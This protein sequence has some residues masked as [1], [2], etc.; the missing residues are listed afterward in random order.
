MKQNEEVFKKHFKRGMKTSDYEM[1]KREYPTLLKCILGA[2]NEVAHRSIVE[3][4]FATIPEESHKR[5]KQLCD[6]VDQQK[7]SLVETLKEH[8]EEMQKFQDEQCVLIGHPENVLGLAVKGVLETR[9]ISLGFPPKYHITGTT[10]EVVL[11]KDVSKEG[12]LQF[13]KRK[14]LKDFNHE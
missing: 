6:A 8:A 7:H 11:S 1:F 4:A 3:K 12:G 9:R 10:F 13:I 2:M 5:V 14:Q